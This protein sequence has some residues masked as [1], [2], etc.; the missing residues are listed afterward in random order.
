MAKVIVAEVE[1][2]VIERFP[3][4]RI[5]DDGSVWTRRRTKGG[6]WRKLSSAPGPKYLLV[7]ITTERGKK[8]K[9]RYVHQLVLEAF[10]GPC[11][12]GMECRH[13]DGDHLNNNS[14]NLVWGTRKDN[15]A[16]KIKHGTTNLGSRSPMAVIDEDMARKIKIMLLEGMRQKD[17]AAVTGVGFR[18]VS[19]INREVTWRHVEIP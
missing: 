5:G 7:N 12:K 13:L 2:R 14:S 17:I 19:N 1:Y 6:V 16:D 10:V 9:T 4:Y 18:T 15:H 3:G 8:G 11:P